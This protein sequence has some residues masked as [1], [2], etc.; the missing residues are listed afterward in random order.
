MTE[1]PMGKNDDG[2][3]GLQMAVKLALEIK[4]GSKTDYKSV[5]ARALGFRRGAY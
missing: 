1:Y 5:I 3:D 4:V 2:P